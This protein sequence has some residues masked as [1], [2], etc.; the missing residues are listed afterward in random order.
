MNH[1]A[2]IVG[3]NTLD[4]AGRGLSRSDD[5]CKGNYEHPDHTLPHNLVHRDH[6]ESDPSLEMF[7]LVRFHPW[8]GLKKNIR[9]C[10]GASDDI[11]RYERF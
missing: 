11:Q 10:S 1:S 3:H 8:D 7:V 4:S 9:M 5:T 2:R 6:G